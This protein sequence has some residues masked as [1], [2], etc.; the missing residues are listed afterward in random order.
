MQR[1]FDELD[2]NSGKGQSFSVNASLRDI[3]LKEGW[4]F[5]LM[6]RHQKKKKKNE[7]QK[8]QLIS[9]PEKTNNVRALHSAFSKEKEELNIRKP[10]YV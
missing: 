4:D 5:P 7:Q 2:L 10:F 1:L 6:T 9:N 8:E 3:G